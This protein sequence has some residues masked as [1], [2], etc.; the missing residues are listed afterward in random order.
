[1]N[2]LYFYSF[3]ITRYYHQTEH[4][5][6]VVCSI[7]SNTGCDSRRLSLISV[8]ASLGAGNSLQRSL[9]KIVIG[10]CSSLIG[11]MGYLRSQISRQFRNNET[12]HSLENIENHLFY[13]SYICILNSKIYYTIFDM[14]LAKVSEYSILLVQVKF[15]FCHS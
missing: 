8:Y 13:C 12:F 7:H 3:D 4:S 6:Y 14:L 11:L 15:I 1:M 2:H 10:N 5:M 9:S